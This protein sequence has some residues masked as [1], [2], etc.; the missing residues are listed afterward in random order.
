MLGD[1][2]LFMESSTRPNTTLHTIAGYGALMRVGEAVRSP[3]TPRGRRSLERYP[4]HGSKRRA[5]VSHPGDQRLLVV[6]ETVKPREK[7]QRPVGYLRNLL[8]TRRSR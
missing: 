6:R 7:N 8:R 4:E 1:I 5:S 2:Y 3:Q